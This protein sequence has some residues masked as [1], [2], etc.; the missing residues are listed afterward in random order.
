MEKREPYA[1]DS[2]D[3]DNAIHSSVG[4][5][6]WNLSLAAPDE[7]LAEVF[8]RSKYCGVPKLAGFRSVIS[9]Y[10]RYNSL[11]Q[12]LSQLFSSSTVP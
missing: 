6:K 9:A 2:P 3:W 8:I 5:M 4:M 1:A 12:D 7:V 11:L 10:Q